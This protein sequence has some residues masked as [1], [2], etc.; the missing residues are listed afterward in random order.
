MKTR[1]NFCKV[2]RL[3]CYQC[4]SLRFLLAT[5]QWLKK[6][7]KLRGSVVNC[8]GGAVKITEKLPIRSLVALP[9]PITLPVPITQPSSGSALQ[10]RAKGGPFHH[11]CAANMNLAFKTVPTVSNQA[12]LLFLASNEGMHLLY[13][14]VLKASHFDVCTMLL[15]IF[16]FMRF[17]TKN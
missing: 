14:G 11:N 13:D 12:C 1:Q 7:K 9:P 2:T 16:L 8:A 3:R 6:F 5:A 15:S 17:L 10:R 4:F